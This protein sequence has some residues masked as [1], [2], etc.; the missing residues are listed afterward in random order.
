M[1]APAKIVADATALAPLASAGAVRVSVAGAVG[2]FA[3]ALLFATAHAVI[4]VPIWS[5]IAD[6]VM[7]ATLAGVGAAWAFVSLGFETG[8]ARMLDRARA[9]A[10]FGALLWL[11]VAPV[12]LIDA[13]MRVGGLAGRIDALDV[14]LA[15]GVALGTGAWLG[16]RRR[17]TTRAAVVGAMA[18]L[19]MVLAMRGPV[20]IPNGPRA[21]G[22][23]LA[24]LPVAALAGATMALGLGR[25]RT[26]SPEESTSPR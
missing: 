11:A 19:L 16:W 23:F 10:R 21:M 13:A 7:F 14:A 3:A 6:G 4:I 1:S 24:V 5:R 12:T 9:G 25:R 17:G 18:T 8:R 22:I 20:P 15:V 26:L 2:G